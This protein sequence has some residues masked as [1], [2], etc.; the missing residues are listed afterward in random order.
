MHITSFLYDQDRISA[1]VQ[2]ARDLPG[3]FFAS[4]L[5][6]TR[7][8]GRTIAVAFYSKDLDNISDELD[9]PQVAEALSGILEHDIEIVSA[10]EGGDG[11]QEWRG[12][13]LRERVWRVPGSK[14]RVIAGESV[15]PGPRMIEG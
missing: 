5:P 15:E 14:S 11:H 12:S 9:M 4:V 6:V 3:G 7:D 10:W 1:F 2:A 13:R 8:D